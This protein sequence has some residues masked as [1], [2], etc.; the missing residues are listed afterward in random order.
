M[1][2]ADQGRF[3]KRMETRPFI[4]VISYRSLVDIEADDVAPYRAGFDGLG[5]LSGETAAE[6]QMVWIVAAQRFGRRPEIGFGKPPSEG[7]QI[8]ELPRDCRG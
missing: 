2:L 1:K 3:A 8:A 4:A 5:G 6:V 7:R